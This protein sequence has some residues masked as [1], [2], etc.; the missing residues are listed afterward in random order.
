MSG[1]ARP[2]QQLH[3]D[4]EAARQSTMSTWDL[5]PDH[6]IAIEFSI[7]SGHACLEERWRDDAPRHPG[8][9]RIFTWVSAL[10]R[11]AAQFPAEEASEVVETIAL[12]TRKT[13]FE[14]WELARRIDLRE[15]WFET[16]TFIRP[17]RLGGP[18]AFLRVFDRSVTPAPAFPETLVLHWLHLLSSSDGTHVRAAIRASQLLAKAAASPFFDPVS[19]DTQIDGPLGIMKA[20]EREGYLTPLRKPTDTGSSNHPENGG[21]I[22]S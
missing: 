10:F 4:L 2:N 21:D 9:D 15:V 22:E 17:E 18:I 16:E 8:W 12:G 19:L 14:K 1:R 3:D 13:E 5:I 6:S 11:Y 20:L 7:E